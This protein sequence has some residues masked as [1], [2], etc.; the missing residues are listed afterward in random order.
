[1][2]T[3]RHDE[4]YEEAAQCSD[5]AGDANRSSWIGRCVDET[6]QERATGQAD[7]KQRLHEDHAEMRKM[8]LYLIGPITRVLNLPIWPR[9]GISY[10][11]DEA[12]SCHRE[13]TI[14]A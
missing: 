12:E 3:L 8:R 7:E 6:G 11:R 1:M 13:N 4:N 9:F 10:V 2:Q 5:A 14:A